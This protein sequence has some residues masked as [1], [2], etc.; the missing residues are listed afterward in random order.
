MSRLLTV[1]SLLTLWQTRSR[2]DEAAAAGREDDE[3]DEAVFKMEAE[4][5]RCLLRLIAAAC[6]GTNNTCQQKSPREF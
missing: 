1:I 3:A 2:A 6:K 4:L 5:D